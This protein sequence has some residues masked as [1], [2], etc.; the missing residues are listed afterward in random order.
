MSGETKPAN[1][2]RAAEE[3]IHW[4][5]PM[6]GGRDAQ[7]HYLEYDFLSRAR[8]TTL[9]IKAKWSRYYLL[10]KAQNYLPTLFMDICKKVPDEGAGV[11]VR[12]AHS[13]IVERS[14]CSGLDFHHNCFRGARR[15]ALHEDRTDLRARRWICQRFSNR[16]LW[17]T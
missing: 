3:E 1:S 4:S 14:C 8:I 17:V 10:L 6:R 9:A 13:W 7:V 5:P 15:G 16:N 11:V 2:I 12:W